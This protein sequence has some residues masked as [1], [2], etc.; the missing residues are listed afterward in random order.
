[1]DE[2]NQP[3]QTE[4]ELLLAQLEK[5]RLEVVNL[6]QESHPGWLKAAIAALVPLI[7]TGIAVGGFLFGIYQYNESAKERQGDQVKADK[8]RQVAQEQADQSRLKS[9]LDAQNLDARHALWD[10][11]LDLYFQASKAA[12]TIATSKDEKRVNAAKE[13]FWNLYWGPLA[14]V[15]DKALTKSQTEQDETV[16]AKMVRFGDMIED[17]TKTKDDLQQQSLVLAHSI[18]QSIDTVW[19]SVEPKDKGTL[20]KTSAAKPK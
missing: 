7:S 20:K 16:E 1:M 9:Q 19:Q 18:A 2:Q 17:K 6:K 13:S 3:A 14:V 12:A 4:H 11:Q 5:V 15:E 10:R 8:E